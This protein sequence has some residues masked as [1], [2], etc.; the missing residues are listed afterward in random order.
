MSLFNSKP[1]SPTQDLETELEQMQRRQADLTR[2]LES[3]IA[4]ANY[5]AAERRALMLQKDDPNDAE[6]AKA[7]A[8][9]RAAD[10]SKSAI[11]DVLQHLGQKI[12]AAEQAIAVQGER[13]E[14]EAVAQ[15]LELRA[16]HIDAAV[17][18]LRDT[19]QVLAKR[20]TALCR[21]L[22]EGGAVRD[23]RGIAADPLGVALGILQAGLRPVEPIL[24]PSS[25]Y[26]GAPPSLDAFAFGQA[27][28]SGP[29]R[30]LAGRVRSGD[31]PA[32]LPPA[33]S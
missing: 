32:A 5:A 27:K 4:E 8:A 21:A 14:R 12:V 10:Q 3:A 11:E 2:R 30:D 9:C 31:A 24:V 28:G 19:L 13:A 18:G 23:E 17:G 6:V 33:L 29:L 20:Y 15:E 22:R 7:D 1:H 26:F 25:E 16:I